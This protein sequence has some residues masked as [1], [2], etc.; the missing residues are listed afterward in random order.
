MN[1]KELITYISICVSVVLGIVLVDQLTK[2]LVSHNM[3]L[4]ENIKIIPNFFHIE[5]I[6]NDGAA[7]G[8]F[9]GKTVILL[10]IPIA[11]IILF[12]FLLT[13]SN[14]KEKKYF[15]LAI[16]FMLGGTIGNFIDRLFLGYVVDFL[17][18]RFGSYHYPNFN[19]A[20]SMLVIGG[21][22]LAVEIIFLETK[23]LKKAE[24]T[25]EV[26]DTDDES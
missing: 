12:I 3:E 24:E 26:D 17:S 20:D 22:L 8:A 16:L 23:R 25:T 5:Y 21:I 19:I 18:F 2:F 10:G 11:A 7:W 1:K 15:T 6:F 9:S 13:R 14:F 4:Q